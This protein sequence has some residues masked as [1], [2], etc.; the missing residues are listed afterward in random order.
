[1]VQTDIMSNFQI[2]LNFDVVLWRHGPHYVKRGVKA[3]MFLNSQFLGQFLKDDWLRIVVSFGKI[4]Q[5]NIFSL[6]YSHMFCFLMLNKNK[7][8]NATWRPICN[9]NQSN[10]GKTFCHFRQKRDGPFKNV[11]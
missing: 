4:I 5:F 8:F 9:S 3:W 11:F 1:M 7:F 2:E 10:T 6:K